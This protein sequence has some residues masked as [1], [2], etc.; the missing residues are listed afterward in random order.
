MPR[1]PSL[2]AQRRELMYILNHLTGY[3]S[4][5]DRDLLEARLR[6]LVVED[7][8]PAFYDMVEDCFKRLHQTNPMLV[9]EARGYF[10]GLL[11][12]VKYELRTETETTTLMS[13]GLMLTSI[14]KIEPPDI[15][16]NEETAEALVALLKKHY[17]N[18]K[19]RIVVH[20]ELLRSNQGPINSMEAGH[21]LIRRMLASKSVL[22]KDERLAVSEEL[23]DPILQQE[24]ERNYGLYLLHAVI[25]V[26]VPKGELTMVHPHHWTQTPMEG[27]TRLADYD[28]NPNFDLNRI[29]KNLWCQEAAEVFRDNTRNYNV[30][31]AEP[32][33]LVRGVDFLEQIMAPLR[34]A[35]FVMNAVH[36]IGCSPSSL[37]A[38]IAIF[39]SRP[40]AKKFYT[41]EIRIALA[42]FTD[43]AHPFSGDCIAIQDTS[44][45]VNVIGNNL[46]A[47][48]KAIG[49]KN[50]V[51]HQDYRYYE[52]E[53]GP[54]GRIFVNP[55]GVSTSLSSISELG[56]PPVSEHLLN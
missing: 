45:N 52:E 14:F 40:D 10:F 38:S 49:V 32:F 22:Y 42:R 23:V 44:L 48:L 2:E 33:P 1:T 39:C 5:A 17:I 50:L 29:T 20:H 16:I 12:E 18:P 21:P 31:V 8:T 15:E 30:I 51:F 37:V 19:A 13:V 24:K 3:S 56:L 27:S 11:N 53:E 9:E 34:L 41:Q 28:G 47:T 7:K 35:P 4:T 43:K 54:R 36:T 46:E 26:T 25:T 6:A 55:Y